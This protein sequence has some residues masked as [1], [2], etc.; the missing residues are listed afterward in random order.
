MLEHFLIEII[1]YIIPTNSRKKNKIRPRAVFLLTIF[2]F[3]VIFCL[4]LNELDDKTKIQRKVWSLKTKINEGERDG[5]D[6]RYKRHT[7]KRK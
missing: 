3:T 7:R 2:I 4:G 6:R 1:A 5:R